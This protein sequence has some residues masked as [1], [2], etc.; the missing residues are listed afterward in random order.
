MAEDNTLQGVIERI[1]AEGQLTR[2]KG[3]NSVKV[4]NDILKTISVNIEDSCLVGNLAS[5]SMVIVRITK[6]PYPRVSFSH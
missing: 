3:T 2:N 1:R 5:C 6:C 4:T